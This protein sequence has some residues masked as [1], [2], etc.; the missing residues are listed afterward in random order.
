MLAVVGALGGFGVQ[1]GSLL[2]EQVTDFS[3]NVPRYLEDIDGC[4]VLSLGHSL[5]IIK[6]LG[7][8]NTV[9]EQYGLANMPGN[10]VSTWKRMDEPN[11]TC[12]V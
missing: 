9:H 7:D 3:E 12:P 5:E 2:A 8:A 4:K 1:V 10:R 6:D 11:S